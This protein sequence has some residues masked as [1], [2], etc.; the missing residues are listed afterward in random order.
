MQTSLKYCLGY[1]DGCGRDVNLVVVCL[2]DK[3]DGRNCGCDVDFD[4]LGVCLTE[5]F[6]GTDFAPLTGNKAGGRV[7]A[8]KEDF[9]KGFE[10]VGGDDCFVTDTASKK[11]FGTNFPASENL[12]TYL[13]STALISLLH[14]GHV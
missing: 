9:G 11:T 2:G 7:G 13:A 8:C 5:G 3:F 6:E 12:R 14:I 10:D 1:D 4:N